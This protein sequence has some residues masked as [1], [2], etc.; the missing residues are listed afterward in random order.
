MA[1]A[2]AFD[3][4]LDLLPRCGG[5]G[6]K[7]VQGSP[8]TLVLGVER[9]DAPPPLDYIE[10]NQIFWHQ[11][12]LVSIKKTLKNHIFIC[13]FKVKKTVKKMVFFVVFF[14]MG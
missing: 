4:D 13:N 1:V 3:L 8:L 6:V 2:V 11:K 5:W 14:G 12:N 7:P 10:T 9:S